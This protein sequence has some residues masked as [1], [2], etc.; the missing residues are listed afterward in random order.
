M[1][2][3]IDAKSEESIKKKKA[4][5]YPDR[6]KHRCQEIEVLLTV[7]L[8]RAASPRTPGLYFAEE[9]GVTGI[10]GFE[11]VRRPDQGGSTEGWARQTS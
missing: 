3:K 8:P 4:A 11:P 10:P 1:R 5:D 2:L 7:R 9:G 6:L